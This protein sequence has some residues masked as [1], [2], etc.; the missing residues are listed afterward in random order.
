MFV[1]TLLIG[2]PLVLPLALWLRTDVPE[3]LAEALLMGG[4]LGLFLAICATEAV[5]SDSKPR[6]A[7]PE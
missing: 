5:G 7:A 2:G 1:W 6:R 3:L 4:V